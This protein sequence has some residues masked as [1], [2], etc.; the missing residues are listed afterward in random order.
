[1]KPILVTG[2]TGKI[3]GAVAAELLARGLPVRAIVRG[4]DRRSNALRSLGA[5][6]IIADIG[7]YNDL[8]TALDGVERAFYCPPLDA[9]AAN[10]ALAF[11]AAASDTRLHSI[12]SL[13]QWLAN[14]ASPALLTRTH[15]LVDRLFSRLPDVTLT[16]VNPGFFADNILNHNLLSMAAQLGQYPWPYGES[17]NAWPSNED[18]ARVAVAALRDPERHDGRVYRP[19]G[20]A[21]L[22]G[23]DIVNT[24]SRVLERRV[25]L[26]PIPDWI[27][28]KA[29]RAAGFP[30]FAQLMMR[31]Y[32]EE[33][34]RGTFAYNAPTDHVRLVTDQEP[35][36]FETTVR[37]YAQAPAAQRTF[38]N[39]VDAIGQ[40][41]KII[42]TPVLDFDRYERLAGVP[43]A[44][45]PR[46]SIESDRWLTEHGPGPD[47]TISH[48]VVPLLKGSR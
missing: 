23:Q 7:D 32:N 15:W 38:R 33:Q 40:M 46:F 27:Y 1:M 41:V 26:V 3:G 25:T 4:Q 16:I 11:A 12:V 47:S 6:L 31:T 19:T 42:A 10:S 43:R 9:H 48:D 14:P 28:F 17:L 21:L 29:A 30:P 20:P 13:S 37:R 34:R 45:E 24:L 39:F 5:Q 22:S 8:R 18:I 35:E 2:A 44:A 36:T